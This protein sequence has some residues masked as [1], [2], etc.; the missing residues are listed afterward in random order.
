MSNN[1]QSINKIYTDSDD[2]LISPENQCIW[3][4]KRSFKM[5][6]TYEFIIKIEINTF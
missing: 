2:K 6:E 1:N 3:S 4:V 5:D